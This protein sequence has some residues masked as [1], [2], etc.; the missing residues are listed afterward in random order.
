DTD[1]P[2]TG[3]RAYFIELDYPS[4]IPGIPYQFTTEIHVKSTLPL[5]PWPFESGIL[6]D[7]SLASPLASALA[8]APSAPADL[9]PVAVG[10][11]IE[12]LA[13]EQPAEEPIASAPAAATNQPAGSAASST[14]PALWSWESPEVDDRAADETD[15]ST[16]SEPQLAFN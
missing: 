9:N 11:A 8:S 13:A 16:A 6:T 15:D 12:S 1:M 2:A 4:G 5:T 3:A 7:D 14:S 10:L